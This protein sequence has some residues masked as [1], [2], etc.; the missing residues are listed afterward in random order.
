MDSLFFPSLALIVC[1]SLGEAQD[2]RREEQNSHEAVACGRFLKG[3]V[4]ITWRVLSF[5]TH[6]RERENLLFR[7]SFIEA[8]TTRVDRRHARTKER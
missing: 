8:P 2:K 4:R 6:E 1:G 5:K 7:L 3:S